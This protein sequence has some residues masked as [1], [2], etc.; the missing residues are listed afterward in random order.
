MGDS[1]LFFS[2]ENQTFFVNYRGDDFFVNVD[3]INSNK[4]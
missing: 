1:N 3:V 2:S 4:Q